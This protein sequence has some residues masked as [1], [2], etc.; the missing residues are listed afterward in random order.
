MIKNELHEQIKKDLIKEGMADIVPIELES[1]V[2]TGGKE[3]EN[4]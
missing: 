3:L 4:A 2:K 1:E